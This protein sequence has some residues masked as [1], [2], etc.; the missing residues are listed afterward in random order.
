MVKLKLNF[1]VLTALLCWIGW[2]FQSSQS[3]LLIPSSVSIHHPCHRH[4]FNNNNNNINV[5]TNTA[6]SFTVLQ[7]AM[8]PITYLRTEWISAALCTNQ[9]PRAAD[10]CL[11]LGTQDGRAV[12]FIPRT[13]RE[14]ITSS[15]EMDGKL[16]VNVQRQLKQSEERRGAAKV[17]YV[18]QRADNLI[19]TENESVDVVIS[20]QAIE[21]MKDNK[22]DWKKSIREAAR[23]LKPGG[24][25]L[26]VE[27]IEIDGE[28]YID[29]IENLIQLDNNENT[30][31]VYDNINNNNDDDKG[32]DEDE[33]KEQE[34]QRYPIF[35]DVGYDDIDFILQPH[36]AGVAIKSL[37]AGMTL[38]ER[39]IKTKLE[40]D[41]KMAEISIKAYE[42]GNKKRRKKK[43][44][45][46]TT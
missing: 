8:D 27:P 18:N 38:H 33:D 22:L 11:Q 34:Q 40:L 14:F 24:R 36:T 44:Q 13:I 10:V 29:Y 4:N 19:Q 9:T 46:E 17:I 35:D 45:Q 30:N 32:N 42:R 3:F 7:M 43:K 28:S 31:I 37:D 21:K 41:D 23:V 5:P 25:L 39:E 12:T 16:P 15:I 1:H 26:W 20:L 6:T 2:F